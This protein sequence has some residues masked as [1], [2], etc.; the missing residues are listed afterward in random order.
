M[1]IRETVQSIE[2]EPVRYD[3][4]TFARLMFC[5]CALPPLKGF[6]IES[7]IIPFA[8]PMPALRKSGQVV[9]TP[10]RAYY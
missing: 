6:G 4:D 10:L 1:Q 8:K 9:L 2:E 5:V 3:P 7:D